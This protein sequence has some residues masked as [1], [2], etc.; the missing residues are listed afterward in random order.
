MQNETNLLSILLVKTKYLNC[1]EK[2]DFSKLT[3]SGNSIEIF[4]L[5]FLMIMNMMWCSFK[6]QQAINFNPVHLNK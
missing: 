2:Y 3:D 1:Q 6:S 5:C 4:P